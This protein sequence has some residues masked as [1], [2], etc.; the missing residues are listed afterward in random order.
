MCYLFRSPCVIE[1]VH[2]VFCLVFGLSSI[3]ALALVFRLQAP[4]W[5]PIPT[6]FFRSRLA[7]ALQHHKSH[8][9]VS[10]NHQQRVRPLVTAAPHENKTN[11]I[12]PSFFPISGW[13]T[14]A[15]SSDTR[16]RSPGRPRAT[17]S[18][19]ALFWKGFLPS[20]AFRYCVY[21]ILLLCRV[22]RFTG[23]GWSNR[24]NVHW[25]GKASNRLRTAVFLIFLR[26]Q[27]CH[28]PYTPG[29]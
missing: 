10:K 25:H 14:F 26:S 8:S 6:L 22:C 24:F 9:V 12:H 21:L 16:Y 13:S 19:L 20:T 4:R 2:H 7:S 18:R 27:S 5:L 3:R 28:L 1:L 11:T 23:I 15:S 17:R 29:C